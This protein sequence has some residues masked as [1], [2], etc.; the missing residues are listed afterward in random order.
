MITVSK[1]TLIGDMGSLGRAT[2][3][4][5]HQFR[6]PLQYEN[7][8]TMIQADH[9]RMLEW[10]YEHTRN[11]FKQHMNTGELGLANWTTGTEP[12]LVIA[13]FED[14]FKV[15]QNHPGVKWTGFRITGT[16]NISSG[17]P[18]Y[19]LWLFAKRRGSE[20]EVY[21]G[22]NAP[23]VQGYHTP[24]DNLKWSPYLKGE[25]GNNTKE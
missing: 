4:L 25:H 20:T 18:V 8:E 16:V 5:I 1:A 7:D 10:D 15:D 13:L 24:L 22:A 12:K 6:F 14:L 21:S 3:K 23:N 11:A 17:Y 19:S 9:D 2:N